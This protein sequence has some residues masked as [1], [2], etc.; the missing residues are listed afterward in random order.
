LRI[1]GV[2]GIGIRGPGKSPMWFRGE[3]PIGNLG[4]D[5]LKAEVF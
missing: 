2:K 5:V 3:V 1:R 4:D